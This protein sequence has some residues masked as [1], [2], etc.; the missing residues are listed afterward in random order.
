[1]N[2][3]NWRSVFLRIG[4]VGLVLAGILTL[5]SGGEASAGQRTAP[6]A[7]GPACEASATEHAGHG[8][9]QAACNSF[10]G[11]SCPLLDGAHI[12]CQTVEGL[13]SMCFCESHIW[14]CPGG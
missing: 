10:D 7:T 12:K 5:G 2:K 6:P 11:K 14:V 3:T 8:P 13:P 9:L 1:M 4:A